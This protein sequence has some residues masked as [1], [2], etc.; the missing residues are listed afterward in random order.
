[1]DQT[2]E[3]GLSESVVRLMAFSVAAIVANIYYAQP[4]LADIAGAFGLTSSEAGALAMI[5]QAG[6]ACGMLLLVPLGDVRERRRL[7]SWLTVAAGVV[8]AFAAAST[9]AVFFGVSLFGVGLLGATVHLVVP[10]AAQL[11]PAHRRGRV[12]GT[13][14]S[15]ILFGVLLARTFSGTL[16]AHLGWRAVYWIAAGL[17]LGVGGLIATRLPGG[18]GEAVDGVWGAAAVD[19]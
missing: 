8:L 13:V 6:T 2:P 18:G 7:I 3:A 19:F 16:G 1:M 12:V 5:S 17:M 11:A 15:G 10:Y 4:L 9:G 14:V